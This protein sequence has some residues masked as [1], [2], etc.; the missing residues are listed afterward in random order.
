MYEHIDNPTD[1][2]PERKTAV[3]VLELRRYDIDIAV[4]SESRLAD[5]G[6]L[7]EHGGGV[8]T[9]IVLLER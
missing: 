1:L 8:S 6:E 5:E 2:C 4:L 3:V 7:V 9:A